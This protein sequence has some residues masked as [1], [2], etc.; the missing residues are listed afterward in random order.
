MRPTS[1]IIAILLFATT[2]FLPCVKAQFTISTLNISLDADGFANINYNISTDPTKANVTL[3]LI[4]SKITDL[5]VTD[6]NQIPLN[7]T[8]GSDSLLIY[9]L[10]SNV[11]V[12]YST[13]TL[14]SKSGD[15]WRANV[16]S[17]V[18]FTV[19]LPEGATLVSVSQI[20]LQISTL[21]Q[22]QSLLLPDGPNEITY[23]LGV[24]GTKDHSLL[25]ITDAETAINQA[26]ANGLVTTF[27]DNLLLKAKNYYNSG[28]YVSA[29]DYATQ[30]K[31]AV[32]TTTGLAGDADSNIKTATT[33]IDK[34]KSDGRTNGLDQAISLLNDSQAAYKSGNYTKASNLASQA[35]TSASSATQPI[36]TMLLI[37]G[38]AIIVVLVALVAILLHR[39]SGRSERIKTVEAKG[40]VDVD[41][42]NRQFPDLREDDK[43]VI[44][45]LA[46]SGGEIYSD[47]IRE[48]LQMPKTSAWRLIKRLSGLGIVGE[49]NVGGRSLIFIEPKFRKES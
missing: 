22:R 6:Q 1:T 7:Y 48:R 39:R 38:T 4:G 17:P 11:E 33:L 25:V 40:M 19:L 49:K 12:S 31:N 21:N 10:G 34:A 45:L 27:A 32:I 13:Q 47:L 9:S 3:P 36:D 29:E 35:I 26:K 16:T 20:P 42:I 18:S 43:V 44:K 15:L 14:T 5:I 37:G 24:I 2:L 30:A 41:L 28:N 23:E 8:I 46:N